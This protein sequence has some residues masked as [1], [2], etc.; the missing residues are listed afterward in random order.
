M[1]E[2]GY[3][4]SLTETDALAERLAS[5]GL[6][7]HAAAQAKAILFA[8][9]A[10]VLPSDAPAVAFFVPGRV[11]V[12]GKHTDYAGGRT[13]VLAAS[14]G[15]ACVAHPRDDEYV[16][17]TA[18]D[19]G[20]A[21]DFALDPDLVPR[22]GHWANY[23]MTVARRIARNFAGPLRGV[24]LALASDLPPAA[25]MSS[26]SALI[27]GV[28]LVLAQRNELS[29]LPEYVEN[30]HDVTDLAGYLGTVENGQ[31]F[32]S[33]VG[34]R[35]VG[36]FGGSEDHTAI[37]SGRPGQ[38]SQY[39][40]CPVR[41]ERAVDLPD[42]YTMAVASSGVVAEKTGQAM[43]RYNAVSRRAAVLVELWRE[44][45]GRDDP[46]LA[47]AL[48]SGP[49]APEKLADLAARSR[50]AEFDAT[51]LGAR[52]AHFVAENDRI[53]PQAGDALAAADLA[54]FGEAV[55]RSQ[56]AAEQLLGNQVP[57]TAWLASEAR[58]CGALAASS[59]G[60]GFGGSVWALVPTPSADGLL[61]QWSAHYRQ[62]FPEQ[63]PYARFFTTSAGPAA[64]R[65]A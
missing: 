54:G 25:G 10:D 31:T 8:Q 59:F 45:T 43:A 51:S 1:I 55:D 60:A 15:F 18:T 4:G 17:V 2:L 5:A 64:F 9:A 41:F 21:V 14:Q 22:S 48:S 58:R 11:E 44:A 7:D 37:L 6:R 19:Q 57:Q 49:D 50:H 53:I 38:I 34:D 16:R 61:N 39:S 56:R 65:V 3:R 46:H 29:R 23:P 52:L 47:A 24:D 33:L 26:S 32:G 40:Y 28:F 35:G 42:G 62:A 13:M 12:L 36:T 27:V 63:A 20:E 30:I